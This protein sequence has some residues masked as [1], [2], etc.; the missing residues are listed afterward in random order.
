[1]KRF[2]LFPMVAFVLVSCS[3]STAPEVA[4]VFNPQFSLEALAPVGDLIADVE[5]LLAAGVLSE[6][7]ANSMLSKLE[8]A[9]KAIQNDKP[10]AANKL[11]AFVNEVEGYINGGNLSAEAGQPLITAANAIIRQLDGTACLCCGGVTTHVPPC[12]GCY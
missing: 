10:S 8:G 11:G 12:T 5:A 9:L 3:D 7:R 2:I 4:D 1:M 6:G